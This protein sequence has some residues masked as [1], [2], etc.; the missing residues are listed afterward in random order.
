MRVVNRIAV[1]ITGAK[2]Y[3]DSTRQHDA[4]AA[5]GTLTVARVK[6]YRTAFLLPEFEL[7]ERATSKLSA[8]GS[9]AYEN[10]RDHPRH[11]PV[12]Q[13]SISLCES[14]VAADFEA[15]GWF[16]LGRPKGRS[17]QTTPMGA[18]AQRLR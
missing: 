9:A 6:P 18:E 1:T 15:E 13:L 11:Q 17:L 4:D 7:E 12:G 5:K 2:A 14:I 16:D 8:N 10:Y 3:M